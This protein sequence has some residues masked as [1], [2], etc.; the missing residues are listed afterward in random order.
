M[1]SSIDSAISHFEYARMTMAGNQGLHGEPLYISRIAVAIAN[2][3]MGLKELA[4]VLSETQASVESLNLRTP[5]A[6]AGRPR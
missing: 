5:P 4:T 3:A 2:L 6:P 1:S